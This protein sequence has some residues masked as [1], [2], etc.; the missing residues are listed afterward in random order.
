MNNDTETE[1]T[2]QLRTQWVGFDAHLAQ[3]MI[4]RAMISPPRAARAWV[5]PLAAAAAVVALSGGVAAV[6]AN[7]TARPSRAPAGGGVTFNLPA[8]PESSPTRQS[9]PPPA[10]P[11]HIG[12]PSS[13]SPTPEAPTK[14]TTSPTSVPT[15]E[16]TTVYPTPEP[17]TKPTH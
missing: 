11:A 4:D 2:R 15:G 17:T 8:S 14:P 10:A 16:P 5:S 13:V 1:L 6:A 7:T 3:D 12:P 9:E